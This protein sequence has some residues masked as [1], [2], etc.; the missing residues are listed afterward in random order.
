MTIRSSLVLCVC[1]IGLASCGGSS[2][3]GPTAPPTATPAPTG[4]RILLAGQSGAYF[5]ASYLPGAIDLSNIDGSVDFWLSSPAFASAARTSSL[6]A[7]VWM[8][9]ARDILMPQDTYAAKLRSVITIARSGN[10]LL[11]VRIVEI[12]DPFGD[13]AAIKAAH[14]QVAADPGNQLVPTNDL[15]LDSTNHLT[16]AANQIVRDRI[17]R[18]L[19]R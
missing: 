8:Q 2:A 10:S 4:P 19:G 1:V 15:E 14:R 5:L 12:P 7:L 17:Y 18:S 11:P 16:P 6:E 3:T 13:R 9:G